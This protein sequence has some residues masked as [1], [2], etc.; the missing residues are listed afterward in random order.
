MKIG[1]II[2]AQKSATSSM[3]RMLHMNPAILSLFEVQLYEDV[4]SDYGRELLGHAPEMRRFFGVETPLLNGYRQMAKRLDSQDYEYSYLF[5]K[6]PGVSRRRTRKVCDQADK[7]VFM[8]RDVRTWLAKGPIRRIYQC[9]YNAAPTAVDY[10]LHFVD[11]FEFVG[12]GLLHV[13]FS[14]FISI[15]EKIPRRV[16]QF[17][18][19]EDQMSVFTEWWRKDASKIAK[20]PFEGIYSWH[21]R[22]SSMS[23][24]R[25]DTS[26]ELSG[27]DFWEELLPIFDRYKNNLNEDIGQKKIEEDKRK[28]KSLRNEKVPLSDL[29]E[30]LSTE[31]L[32]QTDRDDFNFLGKVLFVAGNRSKQLAERFRQ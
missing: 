22:D 14:D 4:V 16:A 23:E 20:E 30:Q 1:F 10:V 13:D 7:V 11:S 21:Q 18:D 28:L 24:P 32:G 19:L 2:G 12:D 26:V 15:S 29:Y 31:R 27:A 9:E 8:V 17:L 5:D 6:V 25:S 3:A